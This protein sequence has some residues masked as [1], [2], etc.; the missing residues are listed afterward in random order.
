MPTTIYGF[1][2]DTVFRD[3]AG[4][5]RTENTP[6][7]GQPSRQSLSYFSNL[8]EIVDDRAARPYIG[9][10]TATTRPVILI[11]GDVYTAELT[12]LDSVDQADRDAF[13]NILDRLFLLTDG[14]EDLAAFEA[15]L[16]TD[17]DYSV[18]IAESLVIASGIRSNGIV[19]DAGSA[20]IAAPKWVEFSVLVNGTGGT[21]THTF[22][23]WIDDTNFTTHY[24]IT[25]ITAVVPPLDYN[26]ILTNA[27]TG[28]GTNIFDSAETAIE[29]V[30]AII[31]SPML[32]DHQ[33][34]L[35]LQNITLYGSLDTARLFPFGILHKGTVPDLLSI[36]TAIREAV[37]ASGFGTEETWRARAPEL[38]IVDQFYI[39]PMWHLFTTGPSGTIYPSV[40]GVAEMASASKLAVPS[41]GGEFVDQY[42]ESLSAVYNAMQVATIPHPD[43]INHFSISA[44]HPTYQNYTSSEPA[45]LL[46]DED[47]KTFSNR[48]NTAMAVAAGVTTNELF[49]PRVDGTNTYI[50]FTVGTTEY[51]VITKE[52]FNNKVGV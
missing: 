11:D 45:F 24:P 52:S 2:S 29:A 27:L 41:L 16:T 26:T 19:Y 37:L 4:P 20:A 35:Y 28:G 36:R 3:T 22:R 23:I 14:V 15:D 7:F 17:P 40:I 38:F 51:Y 48:L 13:F 34:G 50:P 33:T 44:L 49:P 9:A 12:F 32:T 42:L 21:Q 46:M 25:T 31:S 10:F 5:V 30:D 8:Q 18:Y 39:L 43:N 6:G 47:T 1:F